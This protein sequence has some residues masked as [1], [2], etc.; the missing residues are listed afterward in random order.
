MPVIAWGRPC[1]SSRILDV[2]M[3]RRFPGELSCERG[4]IGGF[5]SA[6]ESMRVEER[7]PRAIRDQP[8][9]EGGTE[10]RIESDPHGGFLVILGRGR[11][12]LG[13]A[14]CREKTRGDAARESLSAPGEEGG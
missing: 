10:R 1:R 11:D 6:R 13:E 4:D 12:E 3:I 7:R 2:E 9:L 14:D 8:L 5:E